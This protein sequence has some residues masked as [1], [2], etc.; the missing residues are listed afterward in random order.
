MAFP[1][2]TVI[3]NQVL[4]EIFQQSSL[5]NTVA[6][7]F[8]DAIATKGETVTVLLPETP[9]VR[10]AGGAFD[11]AA[12]SPS[13]ADI[14]LNKWRETQ[15]IKVDLKTASLADLNVLQM[16]A[17]PIAEAIRTDV[18]AAI[19]A[20][21]AKFTEVL[22]D[23]AG[24]VVPTGIDGVAVAPKQKFDAIGAPLD[25]RFVVAGP[26][27]EAEYW[28]AFGL[29]SQSGETGVAEQIRGLMGTKLGM[30]FIANAEAEDGAVIG[31][32]YHRNAIAL[33]TRPM[34][35]SQLAPNTMVTVSYAGLGITVETW[36]DPA[37]SS[38]YLRGQILY[39]VAPVSGKG[40]KIAKLPGE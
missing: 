19:L 39:G 30:Q 3:A 32:G 14:T 27:L 2:L 10:D 28:K 11:P 15:P 4:F 21:I 38:D 23:A 29:Q 33:A 13:A 36:H 24:T 7:D 20:E 22:G 35:V 34:Q 17:S 9:V 8:S 25:G 31:Y 18:E 26:S 16:Y 40:F 37:S 6:R 1:F 12:A 5:L